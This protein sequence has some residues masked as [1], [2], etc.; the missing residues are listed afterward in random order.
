MSD[1]DAIFVRDPR[2]F[3]ST[4]P[5]ADILSHSDMLAPTIGPDDR[6]LELPIALRRYLNVGLLVF[7]NR[8]PTRDLL[9]AWRLE[10][11]AH[12]KA[13]EQSLFNK[14]M[15]AR[16]SS[17]PALESYAKNERVFPAWNGSIMLGILPVAGFSPGPIAFM[18]RLGSKMRVPQVQSG[19]CWCEGAIGA[20]GSYSTNFA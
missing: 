16:N 9:E 10:M 15:Q 14:L 4:Y 8:K 7:R 12:P 6:G 11:V 2:P 17:L 19:G 1:S 20:A 13:W 3:F 18:Q 5:E